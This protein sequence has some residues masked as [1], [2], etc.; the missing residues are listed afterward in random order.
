[1]VPLSCVSLL[2]LT[3]SVVQL[4]FQVHVFGGEL[5]DF[6]VGIFLLLLEFLYFFSQHVFSVPPL[7][8]LISLLSGLFFD[9][10][11]QSHHFMSLPLQLVLGLVKLLLKLGVLDK[12]EQRVLVLISIVLENN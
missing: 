10:V 9:F 7:L 1:M 3:I 2:V 11:L 12:V 5:A 8:L 6:F 4:F